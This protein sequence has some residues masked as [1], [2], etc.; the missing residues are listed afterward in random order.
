MKKFIIT[1]AIITTFISGFI[2]GI[3]VKNKDGFQEYRSLFIYNTN[4]LPHSA[5]IDSVEFKVETG[6]T[7]R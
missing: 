7:A 1:L 6:N 3:I 2:V 4:L 5:I